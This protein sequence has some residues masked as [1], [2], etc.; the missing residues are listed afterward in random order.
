M[1]TI[2]VGQLNEDSLQKFAMYMLEKMREEMQYDKTEI[3][4]DANTCRTTELQNAV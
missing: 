4:S 2:T 1:K 3:T